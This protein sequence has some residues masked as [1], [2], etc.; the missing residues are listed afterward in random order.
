M[1]GSAR[2]GHVRPTGC[3]SQA[4][5]RAMLHRGGCVRQAASQKASGSAHASPRLIWL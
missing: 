2:V 3:P 4:L 5:P 1:M